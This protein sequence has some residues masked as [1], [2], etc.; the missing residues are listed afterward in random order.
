MVQFYEVYDDLEEKIAQNFGRT[1]EMFDDDCKTVQEWMKSQPHLP[2]IMDLN[3]IK[4]YLI[5][6]KCSVEITK[7]K[8][9]LYY[10][11][12]PKMLSL[13]DNVN[14]RLPNM[15]KVMDALYF[16]P[17]PKLTP[18]LSRVYIYKIRDP[19][20][21]LELSAYDTSAHIIFYGEIHHHESL[22]LSHTFILDC[23]NFAPEHFKNFVPSLFQ[24]MMVFYKKTLKL[25]VKNVYVVNLSAF[26][27]KVFEMCKV[28]L[29]SKIVKKVCFCD[30]LVELCDKIPKNV[31][32]VDFGGE[33][34]S[35]EEINDL[36]KLKYLEYQDRFDQVEAMKVAKN[37]RP[38]KLDNDDFL[39]FYGNFKKLELD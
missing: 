37:L 19:K 35:L 28:F 14:P 18:D 33:E 34:K 39:G 25:R 2:E 6:N 9:D 4:N 3:C 13:F 10:T 23:S 17:L 20:L 29:G 32:P 16:L 12:L 21:S 38:Y 11:V 36:L 30:N 27:F 1:K 8:I 5:Y 22:Q 26:A 15:R 31:L 24:K 7:Q